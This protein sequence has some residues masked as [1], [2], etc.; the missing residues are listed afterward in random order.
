MG[1]HSSLSAPR[2]QHTASLH[3][4]QTWPSWLS[5]SRVVPIEHTVGVTQPRSVPYDDDF[6]PLDFKLRAKNSNLKV[7]GEA[8][9]VHVTSTDADSCVADGDRAEEAS[10]N[11]YGIT[12]SPGRV[13][14]SARPDSSASFHGI[15]KITGTSSAVK[16]D[17][18]NTRADMVEK[19]SDETAAEDTSGTADGEEVTK[20]SLKKKK[21]AIRKDLLEAWMV[22]E[23]AR[24]VLYGTWT[25]DGQ[26][27]FEDVTKAYNKKREELME[28]MASGELPEED[29][30]SYPYFSTKDRSA[31]KVRPEGLQSQ[32]SKQRRSGD[33]LPDKEHSEPSKDE[34]KH[35]L[36]AGE[37]QELQNTA[38]D[39][40]D[41]YG[42]AQ[43]HFKKR[44][45]QGKSKLKDWKHK[46][47]ARIELASKRY[48]KKREEL[49]AAYPEGL[50]QWLEKELWTH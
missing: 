38:L 27:V 29:A 8:F 50:L 33:P 2:A 44:P 47:D 23:D 45:P 18:A 36:T 41:R 28:C 37:L 16:N 5:P 35:Q 40:R 19:Y 48:Q 31:P 13:N 34:P 30:K 10:S 24:T 21:R 49:E 14:D 20:Q 26:K 32:A 3:P 42:E 1:G 22:R 43:S 12:G 9:S 25:L 6:P 7:V 4:A 17:D 46:V 39:A 15:L 11:E